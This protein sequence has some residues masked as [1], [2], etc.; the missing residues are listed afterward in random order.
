MQD[1][2]K[3]DD[4]YKKK[5]IVFETINSVSVFIGSVALLATAASFIHNSWKSKSI[6]KPD[7]NFIGDMVTNN[8]AIF[9]SVLDGVSGFTNA[10]NH[11]KKADEFTK[12]LEE[13]KTKAKTS[14]ALPPH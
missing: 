1:E 5:N 3:D 9:F 12:Q 10:L 8:V 13:E 14:P 6:K 2:S 11:N 7:A 4:K